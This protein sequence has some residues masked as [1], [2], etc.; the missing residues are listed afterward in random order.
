MSLLYDRYYD[1]AENL[2]AITEFDV[3]EGQNLNHW[4]KHATRYN[5]NGGDNTGDQTEPTNSTEAAATQK[6]KQQPNHRSC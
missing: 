5:D 3:I 4:M 1:R 2:P 6:R